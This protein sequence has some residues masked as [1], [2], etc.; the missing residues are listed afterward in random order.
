MHVFF[1]TA[2]EIQID[3]P[4]LVECVRLHGRGKNQH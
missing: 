1:S 2:G 4:I 3:Q